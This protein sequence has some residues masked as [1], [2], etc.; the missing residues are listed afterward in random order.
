MGNVVQLCFASSVWLQ[1]MFCSYVNETTLLSFLRS[2]LLENGRSLR[3]PNIFIK[4]QTWWSNDKTIIELGYRKISCFISVS[5][6]KYLPKPNSRRLRQMIDLL[7]T[8]KSRDFA[9][10][11]PIISNYSM[12]ESTGAQVDQANLHVLSVFKLATRADK[13]SLGPDS[14]VGNKKARRGVKQQKLKPSLV[15]SLR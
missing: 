10:P 8:D 2:L 12:A 9:Q 14:A 11:R 15:P 6:V 13:I 3:F 1:I 4:K 5:Q 7:V